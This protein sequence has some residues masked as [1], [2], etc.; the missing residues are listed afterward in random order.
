MN[1][2]TVA[3]EL[4]SEMPPTVGQQRVELLRCDALGEELFVDEDDV[5]IEKHRNDRRLHVLVND[6]SFLR[7]IDLRDLDAFVIEE[8]I[9]LIEQELM[10]VRI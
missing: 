10:R 9:H 8:D 1:A 2:E 5:T 4:F 3:K 7:R 6:L